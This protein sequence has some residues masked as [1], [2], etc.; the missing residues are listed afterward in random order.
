MTKVG[1]YMG[2][3]YSQLLKHY[4]YHGINRACPK[5]PDPAPFFENPI[6][7]GPDYAVKTLEA[8]NISKDSAT[9]TGLLFVSAG[10]DPVIMIGFEYR[11]KGE[12][13]YKITYEIGSFMSCE[14]EQ[15]M[16]Y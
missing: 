1:F 6:D 12:D 14:Y 3:P 2:N 10:S 5:P 9:L 7:E 16:S 11:P 8:I 15:E 13:W 4:Q